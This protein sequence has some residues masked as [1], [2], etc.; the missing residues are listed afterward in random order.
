[1]NRRH[2]FQSSDVLDPCR[3]P[4]GLDVTLPAMFTLHCVVWWASQGECPCLHLVDM[5]FFPVHSR[6]M[7]LLLLLLLHVFVCVYSAE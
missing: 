6:P 3:E 5:H 4:V 1:M 2:L 7:T